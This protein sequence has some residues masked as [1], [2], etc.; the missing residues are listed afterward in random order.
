[1]KKLLAMA[2]ESP[3]GKIDLSRV[4][5]LLMALAYVGESGYALWKGQHFD[6]QAFGV[7]AG[8]ITTGGGAG[9]WL[10]GRNDRQADP[11]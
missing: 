2:F 10:H 4:V 7:G 11:S 3:P 8:A 9:V 1:M 6:W 5:M